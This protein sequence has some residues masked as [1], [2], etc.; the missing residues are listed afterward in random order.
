MHE[1][2]RRYGQGVL[3][4]QPAGTAADVADELSALF[5]AGACDGLVVT[6][7]QPQR[8][9]DALLAGVVPELERRGLLREAYAGATLREHLGEG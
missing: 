4:P 2:S 7:A 1:V 6:P 8:G 9:F 5:E 3:V